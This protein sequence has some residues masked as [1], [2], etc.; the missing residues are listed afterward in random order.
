MVKVLAT[1]TEGSVLSTHCYMQF[2]FQRSHQHL[3]ASPDIVCTR[4]TSDEGP[5]P[6][7]HPNTLK[8]NVWWGR[9]GTESYSIDKADLEFMHVEW[10]SHSDWLPTL[11]PKLYDSALEGC[12]HKCVP[13]CPTYYLRII[14]C[15][16]VMEYPVGI[17]K[18]Q[19]TFP[20]I[21]FM[22]SMQ[23]PESVLR[24]TVLCIFSDVS[25]TLIPPLNMH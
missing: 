17:S 4:C 12:D 23:H 13:P 24:I 15:Q 6:L 5:H 16:P 2:H 8:E 18:Q 11:T 3:L 25:D 7:I 9:F 10:T 19:L 22:E 1:L 21:H 20:I 14:G